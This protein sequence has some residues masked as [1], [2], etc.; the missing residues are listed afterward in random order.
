[1]SVLGG[2][3]KYGE[4]SVTAVLSKFSQPNDKEVF[5][6]RKPSELTKYE[7]MEALNLM[8]MIKEKEMAR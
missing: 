5:E 1:M 2:I 4:K 3:K 7:R 6:A 8:A